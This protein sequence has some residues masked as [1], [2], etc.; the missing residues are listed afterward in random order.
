MSLA[1]I[2]ASLGVLKLSNLQ[3]LFVHFEAGA[4]VF[5]SASLLT[6]VVGHGRRKLASSLDFADAQRDN[7][8]SRL[9]SVCDTQLSFHL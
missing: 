5:L 4:K 6:R 3:P 9:D 8:S 7:Y 2:G 1:N